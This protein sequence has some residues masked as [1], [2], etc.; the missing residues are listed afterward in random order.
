[1]INVLRHLVASENYCCFVFLFGAGRAGFFF[2]SPSLPPM[3]VSASAELKGNCRTDDCPVVLKV[4]S[5]RRSLAR[6][7]TRMFLKALARSSSVRLGLFSI[8]ALTSSLVKVCCAPKAFSSILA[9]GTPCSTR[10]LLTRLSRRSESFWLYSAGPRGSAWPSSIKCAS[11]LL[12]RYFLKSV[13][14]AIR[15]RCWLGTRPAR[16]SLMGGIAVGK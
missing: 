14:S 9:S 8:A 4:M 6:T 16:G 2:I 5:T 7:I 1:M 3:S 10:K 13:A 15:V 12:S 11:G